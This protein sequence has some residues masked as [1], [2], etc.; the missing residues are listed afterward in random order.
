MSNLKRLLKNQ[1]IR[2]DDHRSDGKSIHDWAD[3]SADI[4]LHK[5]SNN[6][7]DG[8][9]D[10]RIPLNNIGR[11]ATIKY[12]ASN[13]QESDTLPKSLRKEIKT[14]FKR[15]EERRRF[16]E[17]VYQ[18]LGNYN[19]SDN[20]D[21]RNRL[22]KKIGECFD[23]DFSISLSTVNT[24]LYLAFLNESVYQIAFNYSTHQTFIGEVTFGDTQGISQLSKKQWISRLVNELSSILN[25]QHNLQ[26]DYL[27]REA[28]KI[29]G[30]GNKTIKK[31]LEYISR[32]Y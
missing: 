20:D 4:H 14:A 25:T 12:I 29:S 6:K 32:F 16:L 15:I 2:I 13:G 5:E 10:I 17:E 30:I 23:I 19:W 9:Y 31:S 24:K 22:A 1:T 8:H 21:E 18:E 7:L 11:Q 27:R 3:K 28:S 26:K